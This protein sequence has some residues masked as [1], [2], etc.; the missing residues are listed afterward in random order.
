[1]KSKG[2]LF[3]ISA[4]SGAGKTSL[5]TALIEK[6][7]SRIAFE[8]PITYTTRPPRGSEVHGQDY[9]F[10]SGQ[11]FQE[12]IEQGFFLE[13]SD[14]YGHY[15]GSACHLLEKLELGVSQIIIV[16]K[17]GARAIYSKVPEAVL[18]WLTINE[19]N[20]LE[21]RLTNRA[22][23]SKKEIK[24]RLFLAKKEIFEENLEKFFKYHIFN[25]IFENALLELESMVVSELEAH[26]KEGKK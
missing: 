26:G 10:I 15:Y 13:W 16:D 8:R 17:D 2:L 11:E 12:K 5:V 6:V 25:D 7:S 9:Y 22:Q 18:I 23:N 24:Q 4:P 20:N 21:S 3:V 14:A 19:I 1:M